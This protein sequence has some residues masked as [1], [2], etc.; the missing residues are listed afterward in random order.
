MRKNLP[1]FHQRRAGIA[2]AAALFPAVVIADELRPATLGGTLME[3]SCGRDKP[4]R[5]GHAG[6]VIR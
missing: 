3:A 5:P 1:F 2:G 4:G 6:I